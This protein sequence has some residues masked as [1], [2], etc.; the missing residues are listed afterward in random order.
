MRY[1][2]Y[3]NKVYRIFHTIIAKDIIMA[4]EILKRMDK[5]HYNNYQYCGEVAQK[6]CSGNNI[7]F[8]F[9]KDKNFQGDLFTNIL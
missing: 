6:F 3:Y 9:I 7:E 8:V 2:T 1:F 5:Y 4:N